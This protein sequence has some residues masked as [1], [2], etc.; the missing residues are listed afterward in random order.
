MRRISLALLTTALVACA[1]H[2]PEDVASS[3][4]EAAVTARG[5]AEV[6]S[7]GTNPGALRMFEH[8]PKNLQPNAPV[9]VVLHGCMTNALNIADVGWN[10]LADQRGFTVVYPQQS[11]FNNGTYCFNW[12]NA[13]GF[14]HDDAERGGGE[15]E[16]IREMTLDAVKR[17]HGDPNRVY[18]A[19]FSAGAAMAVDLA[20]VYPDVYAGVA[21][22]AGVPYGC[23]STLTES[24]QCMIPGISR[25][26]KEH[27]ARVKKAFPSYSGRRPKMSIWQGAIDNV[28]WPGNQ[29]ELVKQWSALLGVSTK[30]S[31]SNTDANVTHAEWK[32]A[33]GDVV[34]ETYRIADMWHGFP[35]DPSHGCGHVAQFVP[36]EGICGAAKVA[37]FFGL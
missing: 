10:D 28:V 26:S 19:G 2:D 32:D 22:F 23:A 33:S 37:D 14:G 24:V 9:V 17:H 20:A 6:T 29:D 3:V 31:A 11:F 27:A 5:L 1:A 13:M 30:P 4:D 7:F 36:D 34:L 21:S 18:A 8:V 16:S 15:S 12:A 25:T 35:V